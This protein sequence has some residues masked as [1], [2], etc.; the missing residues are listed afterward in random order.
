M[1]VERSKFR[2]AITGIVSRLRSPLFTAV[3]FPIGATTE[4]PII[5]LVVQLKYGM[6]MEC[7]TRRS[8][9]VIDLY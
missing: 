7:I 1:A 3:I 5:L 4:T 2:A 6:Y 9:S 8:I